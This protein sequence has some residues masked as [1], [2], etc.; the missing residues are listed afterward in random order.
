MSPQMK[1]ID[2]RVLEEI[3]QVVLKMSCHILSR[4]LILRKS[5]IIFLTHSNR[6]RALDGTFKFVIPM[7]RDTEG[8]TV[9]TVIQGST[10]YFSFFTIIS[11]F[12][13]MR[14]LGS[15]FSSYDFYH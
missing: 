13:C 2:P 4:L 15:Y 6:C 9:L 1:V 10:V 8:L 12:N 5:Y 3:I 14:G 11:Q 7:L